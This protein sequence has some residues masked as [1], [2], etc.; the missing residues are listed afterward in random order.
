M[1]FKDTTS[2]LA[3]LFFTPFHL[4]RAVNRKAVNTIFKVFWCDSTGE[5][6]PKYTNREAD[7]LTTTPSP[8]LGGMKWQNGASQVVCDH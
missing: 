3:G 7:A 6:K 4:H 8:Q 2:K 5:I 1:S